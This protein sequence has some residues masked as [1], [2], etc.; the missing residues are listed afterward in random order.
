MNYPEEIYNCFYIDPGPPRI[1]SVVSHKAKTT[2][3]CNPYLVLKPSDMITHIVL[4]IHIIMF[5][6]WETVS[7]A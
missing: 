7:Q 6:V 5:K 4:S 2:V 3:S 1:L